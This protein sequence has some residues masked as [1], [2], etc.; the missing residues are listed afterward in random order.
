MSNMTFQE[1]I[2]ENFPLLK[3]YTPVLARVHGK[4]HPE[5]ARV[6]DI[7]QEIQ[8]TVKTEDINQVDISPQFEELRNI[9]DNYTVP[10]DGCGTY[11]ET[12]EMLE[13]AD[14]AYHAIS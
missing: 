4:A 2:K 3:Q 13:K 14:Q 8:D 6:R 5:L 12:Y 7:F 11:L 10:S 1:V 9:T